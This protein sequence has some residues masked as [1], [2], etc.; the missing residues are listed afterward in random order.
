[1][2]MTVKLHIT[3]GERVMRT[4]KAVE[5]SADEAAISAPEKLAKILQRYL[6]QES[7]VWSGALKKSWRRI[8]S[9][10]NAWRV[11]STE[12][13][14]SVPHFKLSGPRWAGKS[15]ALFPQRGTKGKIRLRSGGFKIVG[16]RASSVG[17]ANRAL[18]RTERHLKDVLTMPIDK[19]MKKY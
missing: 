7:P 12:W 11:Q 2:P 5:K 4:V 15:Y 1:M 13:K 6:I 17:Y 14:Y 9:K 18:D 16:P 10:R 3:G 19:A 8:R